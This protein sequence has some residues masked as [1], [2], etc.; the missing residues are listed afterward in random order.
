MRGT[1]KL[2]LNEYVSPTQTEIGG[3]AKF[4]SSTRTQSNPTGTERYPFFWFLKA[5]KLLHL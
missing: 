2:F 5:V 4:W 3:L 1:L